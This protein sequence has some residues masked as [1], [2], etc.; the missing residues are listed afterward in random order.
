MMA[1]LVTAALLA[2]L[3]LAALAQMDHSKMTPEQM[4][5]HG[6]LPADQPVDHSKMTPEQMKQHGPLPSEL[7]PEQKQLTP[8]QMLEQTP[9]AAPADA[10][11]PAKK[12]T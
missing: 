1:G 11:A 8:E 7:K 5:Q 12:K 4:Q 9:E 10:T 2:C 6:P 3:P